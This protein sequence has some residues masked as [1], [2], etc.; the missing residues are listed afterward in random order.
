MEKNTLSQILYLVGGIIIILGIVILIGQHWQGIG[1]VARVLVTLG[2]SIVFYISGVLLGQRT[3]A[4]LEGTK[5]LGRL[6]AV[7]GRCPRRVGE[8]QDSHVHPWN[9]GGPAPSAP[10]LRFLT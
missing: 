9:A 10:G 2:M 4:T 5:N 3:E 7:A 6:S 1:S 8:P